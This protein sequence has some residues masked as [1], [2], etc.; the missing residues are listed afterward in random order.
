MEVSPSD[1]WTIFNKTEKSDFEH[2]EKTQNV[3]FLFTPVEKH[4]ALR[5]NQFYSSQLLNCK[6]IA[7]F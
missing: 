6:Q 2:S 4:V 1:K 7:F 3:R 5:L